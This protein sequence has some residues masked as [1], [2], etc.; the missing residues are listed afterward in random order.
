MPLPNDG[1]PVPLP[2]ATPRFE[3]SRHES[4]LR[5]AD[6]F[7]APRFSLRL[8]KGPIGR[9]SR[10]IPRLSR[11]AETDLTQRI[12]RPDLPVSSPRPNGPAPA[13]PQFAPNPDRKMLPASRPPR[14]PADT[15]VRP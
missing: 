1:F 9:Q 6:A 3:K 15:V 13:Q 11:H 5:N 2:Q 10:C 8:P 4:I 14:V 7:D 12:D